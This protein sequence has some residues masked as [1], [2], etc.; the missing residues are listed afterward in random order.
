MAS[1]SQYSTASGRTLQELDAAVTKLVRAGHRLYGN[2]YAAGQGDDALFC[3]ALVSE[4]GESMQEQ[5]ER[6]VVAESP[7]SVLPI[8]MPASR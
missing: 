8:E 2:P 7:P 5:I 4:E 3:Q 6:A 1:K